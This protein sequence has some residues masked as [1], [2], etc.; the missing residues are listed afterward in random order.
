MQNCLI[1]TTQEKPKGTLR[2][3]L[4]TWLT[5][6]KILGS[7]CYFARNLKLE[8]LWIE[9]FFNNNSPKANLVLK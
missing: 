5:K 8:R 2:L 3:Y 1:D 6:N 7:T 4:A 9:G